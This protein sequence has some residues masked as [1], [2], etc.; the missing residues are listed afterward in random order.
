MIHILKKKKKVIGCLLFLIVLCF[1]SP[2]DQSFEGVSLLILQLILKHLVCVIL[3]LTK[4]HDAASHTGLPVTVHITWA[5]KWLK[6]VL[7]SSP[8]AGG[9]GVHGSC[10]M[11]GRVPQ[12]SLASVSVRIL[13]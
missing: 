2:L 11:L 6:A 12:S 7:H 3:F 13:G 9:G 1:P 4:L 10:Y 5:P 8:W